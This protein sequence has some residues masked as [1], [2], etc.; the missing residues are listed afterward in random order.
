MKLPYWLKVLVEVMKREKTSRKVISRQTML[1]GN[2]FMDNNTMT[3]KA[4]QQHR[5]QGE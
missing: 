3:K 5:Q 4:W 2:K 1:Q